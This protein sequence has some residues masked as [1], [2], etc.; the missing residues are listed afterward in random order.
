MEQLYEHQHNKSFPICNLT[1]LHSPLL[2]YSPIHREPPTNS[3]LGPLPPRFVPTTRMFTHA[4]KQNAIP[5]K[6]KA[7]KEIMRLDIFQQDAI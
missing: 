6:R 3:T 5:C 2:L 7:K 4:Y 1:T